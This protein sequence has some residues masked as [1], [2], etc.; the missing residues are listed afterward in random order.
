MTAS[1]LFQ[2]NRTPVEIRNAQADI[3][4]LFA[5]AYVVIGHRPDIFTGGFGFASLNETFGGVDAGNNNIVTA[6]QEVIRDLG[7][8]GG[9]A[10]D[11]E[12][13]A[14][15]GDL[16]FQVSGVFTSVIL[17]QYFAPR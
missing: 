10:G 2:V 17:Q 6:V 8:V 7:R 4:A 11:I 9:D 15:P 14:N 1:S 13:E 5:G 12:P 16:E 3:L